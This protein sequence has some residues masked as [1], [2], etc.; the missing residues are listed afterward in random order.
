MQLRVNLV[1][2]LVGNA[3]EGSEPFAD[4]ERNC[5]KEKR[6]NIHKTR[7]EILDQYIFI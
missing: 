6:Q 4:G 3:V 5:E 2:N 7:E 1:S